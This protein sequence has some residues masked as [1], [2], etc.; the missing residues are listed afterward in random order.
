MCVGP[1]ERLIAAPGGTG[2]YSIGPGLN[3]Y[4]S[5]SL[6][7]TIRYAPS[8]P[9]VRVHNVC[10]DQPDIALLHNE[11]T[12]PS[13]GVVFIESCRDTYGVT[14]HGGSVT[15]QPGRA[16]KADLNTLR[17]RCEPVDSLSQPG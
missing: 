9:G 2:V 12:G 3:A 5:R 10:G 13:D 7:D 4:L 6:V 17:R 14:N 15:H 16:A 8:P 1:G 11:H